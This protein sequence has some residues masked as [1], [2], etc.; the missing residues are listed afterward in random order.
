MQALWNRPWVRLLLVALVGAGWIWLTRAPANVNAGPPPAPRQD[1]TAPDFTVQTL[2]GSTIA[3]HDLRGHVVVLNFWATWCSPCKAEM[4]TL[5]RVYQDTHA[6]G[7]EIVAVTVEN[8]TVA[9]QAFVDAYRL[10]F[11]IGVD[12]NA[13]VSRQYRIQGTPTTFFIDRAGIIRWVV[14]GGPMSEGLVRSK[15]EAL[16]QQE[17]P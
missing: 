11:P 12:A 13:A 5:Q 15:V 3:L 6:Q 10:T 14:V 16:L 17:T 7:V 1:F 9:L 8:D 2:D 4:P